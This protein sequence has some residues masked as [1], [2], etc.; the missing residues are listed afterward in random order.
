MDM[1]LTYWYLPTATPAVGM[2]PVSFGAQWMLLM[3]CLARPGW[4]SGA[5]DTVSP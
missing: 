2:I 4:Y 3:I 5:L 1:K